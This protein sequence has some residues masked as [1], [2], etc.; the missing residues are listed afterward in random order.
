MHQ[1][2]K[3]T[4]NAA[5]DG[6]KPVINADVKVMLMYIYETAAIYA[7]VQEAAWMGRFNAPV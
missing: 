6:H 3:R 5:K 2:D 4:C 1:R 7:Q